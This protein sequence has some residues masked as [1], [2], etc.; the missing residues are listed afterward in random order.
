MS[1]L[2]YPLRMKSYSCVGQVL[3]FALSNV[4]FVVDQGEVGDSVRS[5][6]AA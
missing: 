3:N 5:C 6:P 4:Q 2:Y 1:I